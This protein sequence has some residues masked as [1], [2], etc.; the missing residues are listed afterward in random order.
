MSQTM[1]EK[2]LIHGEILGD[3]PIT[4]HLELI[5]K[6]SWSFWAAHSWKE[7]WEENLMPKVWVSPI[8]PIWEMYEILFLCYVYIFNSM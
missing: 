7:S 8:S 4:C 3:T 6:F 2:S 5:F 1:K